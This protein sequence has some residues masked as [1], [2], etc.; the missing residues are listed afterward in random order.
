MEKQQEYQLMKVRSYRK[1]IADG[2][3]LYTANFHRLFKASW[4]MVLIYALCCGAAG[5]LAA[6][7]LLELTMAATLICFVVQLLAMATIL[8]KQKEHKETDSITIPSR[9]LAVSPRLMGRTLKGEL[10]TLLCI[11]LPV[12]LLGAIF[13]GLE[14]L[15][16]QTVGNHIKTLV[17]FALVLLLVIVLLCLP[18]YHVLMKYLM[19]AP[20]NYWK[21]LQANYGKGLRHWGLL[22]LVLLI[23]T[24]LVCVAEII[25]TLPA[26]I[27]SIANQ[28][29]QEGLLMGDPLG[30]PS[31]MNVLTCVTS[32]LC[33]FMGFYVSLPLLFHIYYIY[34]SIEA[35]EQEREQQK[36][37]IQ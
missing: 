3:H 4:L 36:H 32:A 30:M 20:C 16:P 13:L 34:G 15:S 7:N 28:S 24:L 6:V 8:A 37:D 17:I 29:A 26:F 18:L 2:F 22:F 11:L 14:Q 10:F 25:V 5:T 21:T 1:V 27:L 33:S 9:W 23:S 35:Q 19:E 31:Y 12:I